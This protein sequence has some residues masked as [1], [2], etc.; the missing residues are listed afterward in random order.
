VVG[1]RKLAASSSSV[2]MFEGR[3][4]DSGLPLLRLLDELAD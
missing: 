4:L 2:E 1:T 3:R